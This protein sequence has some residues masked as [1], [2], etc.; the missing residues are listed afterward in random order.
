MR[1]RNG[2]TPTKNQTFRLGTWYWDQQSTS[3]NSLSTI[4]WPL[5]WSI[6][7]DWCG[8]KQNQ[9]RWTTCFLQKKTKN[10]LGILVKNI[11]NTWK[12]P[13]FWKWYTST[14]VYYKFMRRKLWSKKH[15]KEELWGQEKPKKLQYLVCS[16][17]EQVNWP[18]QMGLCWQ[19][20]QFKEVS[21]PTYN[22][23]EGIKSKI[24]VPSFFSVWGSFCR[25]ITSRN[26]LVIPL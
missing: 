12:S 6:H 16:F 5:H 4:E 10:F 17:H 8:C 13:S 9:K 18:W 21:T 2:I 14:K 19:N 24:N 15:S 26:P 20:P 25:G 7:C 22:S 23:Q 3:T 11:Q 1:R